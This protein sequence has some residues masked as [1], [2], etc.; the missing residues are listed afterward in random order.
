[1]G[2]ARQAGLAERAGLAHKRHM[3]MNLAAARLAVI[4]VAAGRGVRAGDGLAKQYRKIGGVPVLR[5]SLRL[6]SECLGFSNLILPVIHKDDAELFARAADGIATLS[7]VIGGATRQDSVLAGLEALIPHAPD[8]VLIH[9]GARPFLSHAVIAR[10]LEA[11]GHAAG[12]IAAIPVTD[13]LKSGAHGMILE[14]VPRDSLWR[15]QTPQGFHFQAILAAHRACVG[16]ALT[17]DASVLRHN[18]GE[19]KLVMGDPENFKITSAEDFTRAERMALAALSDIRT[20]SGFDVHRFGGGD[21]VR[22]CGLKIPHSHGLL[23]H[24]DADVGLHALTDAI[25]GALGEGDIGV[26]FPPSDPQWRGADSA[27][28][29]AHACSLLAKRGGVIAHLDLTLI[30]ERP[31]IGPHRDAMRARIAE[32]TGV[33][34]ARVSVKATTTEGLGFTGRAEG[35][36]AQ[37]IATLRL[38]PA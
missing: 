14:D 2:R 30:C 4:I 23:G 24:S 31:K 7:P 17:D 15:A 18:G 19:V 32:I 35:I 11:L 5:Y 25:L 16:R 8:I 27:R 13:S 29:L 6:F 22:L 37:A 38:P 21:H 33:A 36:A 9:D 3:S 26:H 20:G 1:M 28:F 12:A 34:A 10:V